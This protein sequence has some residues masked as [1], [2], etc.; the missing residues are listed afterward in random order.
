MC[1]YLLGDRGQLMIDKWFKFEERKESLIEISAKTG[2]QFSGTHLETGKSLK[3]YDAFYDSE[4][5]ECV[6]AFY[7]DDFEFFSYDD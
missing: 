1:D 4:S 6:R 5:A 7:K 2:I 3:S